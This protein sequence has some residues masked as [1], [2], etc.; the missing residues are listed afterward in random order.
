MLEIKPRNNNVPGNVIV[1]NTKIL[2]DAYLKEYE[3]GVER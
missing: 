3:E 2:I 1:A